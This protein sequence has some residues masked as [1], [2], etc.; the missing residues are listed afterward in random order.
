MLKR[1]FLIG[2]FVVAASAVQAAG[3]NVVLTF[4]IPGQ[5]PITHATPWSPGMTVERAMQRAGIK[6]VTGWFPGLGDALLI[7]EGTPMITNGA[8]GSPFWWLCVNGRAP[9]R[10]MS[11]ALIP[12]ARSSVVWSWTSDATCKP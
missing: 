6:Y 2:L 11:E 4:N 3:R 1:A 7:A 8:L 12:S 5:A 9:K 10:G